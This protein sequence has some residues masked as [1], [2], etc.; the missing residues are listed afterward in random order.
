MDQSAIKQ[1]SEGLIALSSHYGPDRVKIPADYDQAL[2]HV[3]KFNYKKVASHPIEDSTVVEKV[4]SLAENSQ[5]RHVWIL[6]NK[7]DQTTDL[8]TLSNDDLANATS[9]N[10]DSWYIAV[11]LSPPRF[12][13]PQWRQRYWF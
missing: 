12:M 8:Y 1:I 10:T 3:T 9:S 7:Y 11:A 6:V 5:L 4:R 2:Q 13:E